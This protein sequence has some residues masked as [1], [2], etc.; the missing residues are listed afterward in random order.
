MPLR[1]V[2]RNRLLQVTGFRSDRE[3]TEEEYE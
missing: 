1:I 3:C 2:A